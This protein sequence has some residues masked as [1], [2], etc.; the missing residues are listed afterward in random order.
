MTSYLITGANRGIGLELSRQAAARGAHVFAAC[1][2]P[3]AAMELHATAA[4]CAGRI[5][6]VALE[7]TSPASIAALK[8]QIGARPLDV[9]INNAGIMGADPQSPTDMDYDAFA[10]V[11]AV[12]TIA[13]LR[14]T[15]AFLPN[16]EAAKG[17]A[18][19]ISSLMGSFTFPETDKIAYCTSKTA[20]NRVFHALAK[21]VRTRGIAVA[22]LSP[23]WVR[24]D[25]GGPNAALPVEDSVSGLLDQIAGWSMEKSGKFGNFAGA[26]Q[27]W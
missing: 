20:V 15:N 16:L 18:V 23:G 10:Q 5:E 14:I 11:L 4:A 3:G 25:M 8:A 17:K 13:P 7:V 2:D 19:V 24:T 9:L 21:D 1:R 26:T 6:V 12:N 27:S 22:I